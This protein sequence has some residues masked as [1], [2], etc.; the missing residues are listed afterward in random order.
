ML[1]LAPDGGPLIRSNCGPAELRTMASRLL[2]IAE[3][4]EADGWIGPH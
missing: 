3:Q 1:A 4:V 2:E